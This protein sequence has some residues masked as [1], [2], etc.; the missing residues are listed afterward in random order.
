MNILSLV[1]QNLDNFYQI[2]TK[3]YRNSDT[4]FFSQFSELNEALVARLRHANGWSAV[5]ERESSQRQRTSPA[6]LSCQEPNWRA[7]PRVFTCQSIRQILP[8]WFDTQVACVGR[9]QSTRRSTYCTT[10]QTL[11]PA[12]GNHHQHSPTRDAEGPPGETISK[13]YVQRFFAHENKS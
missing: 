12:W 1:S 11:P 4:V 8:R 10:V 3:C 7:D 5:T 9:L 2:Q 6:R 13:Q